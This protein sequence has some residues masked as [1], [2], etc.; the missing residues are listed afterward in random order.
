MTE[1]DIRALLERHWSDINNQEI[2]HE[3]YHDDVVLEF[4]Q[5]GERLVGK[6]N[7]RAMRE[8]Y[9]AH[10]TFAIQRM[11]GR[12]DLWVTEGVITYNGGPPMRTITIMEFAGPSVMRE[13]IYVTEPFDPP[14]WRAPW[15]QTA[16]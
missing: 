10:L 5:S 3:I 11:R 15:V 1:P 14:A 4:P 13:A 2:V 7:I 12:D 8:A 9:P 16:T 6:A